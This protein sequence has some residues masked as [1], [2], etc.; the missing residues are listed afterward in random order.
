MRE[1][2]K[3]FK[4]L[5]EYMQQHKDEITDEASQREL[6]DR[7]MKEYNARLDES[8]DDAPETADDYLELAMSASSKKKEQEYLKKALEL[9]PEN[10]DAECQLIMVD[11]DKKPIE[12][13]DKLKVL[14]DKET[15]RL[16]KNGEFEYAG[17]FWGILETRPYM[18]ARYSYFQMLHANGMIHL[19][20]SEANEMLRLCEDDNLGVRYPLM[21]LYAYLED[22]EHAL[23]LHK[24][25]EEYDETQMLLPL[26]VLYYK[27]GQFDKAEGY[28]KRLSAANAD[29]RAFLKD[30]ANDNRFLHNQNPYGYRPGTYEEFLVEMEYSILLFIGIPGFADWALKHLPRRTSK[31]KKK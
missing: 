28:L 10:V 31:S 5:E 22:E 13:L 12:C 1:T 9:D 23:A 2:E 25:F 6:I 27:L 29:T 18:R 26:V 7:F 4:E 24:K 11:S 16:E 3:V 17:D 15:K 20:I 21:H 19:A 30:L 14:I 8:E